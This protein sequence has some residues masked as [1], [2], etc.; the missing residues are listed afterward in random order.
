[1]INMD[2]NTYQRESMRT[3]PFGGVTSNDPEFWNALSNYAL[4]LVGE[5]TEIVAAEG[6]KDV[7][8]KEIGDV[9]H[10]A[11]GLLTFIKGDYETESTNNYFP[12]T[13]Q[14]DL[15]K[16]VLVLAGEVSEMVKKFVYHGHDLDAVKMKMTLKVLI[17]NLA[18]LAETYDIT[19]E[20]VCE[21]NINKLKERYPNK[22]NSKDSVARVDVK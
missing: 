12:P 11:F 4:G 14:R 16:K 9:A 13:E 2:L 1:M 8:I 21:I 19:L 18:E 20:E 22:F 5:A 7:S 3:M 15:T 10:Y 17:K 6:D